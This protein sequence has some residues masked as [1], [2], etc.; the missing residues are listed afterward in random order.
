MSTLRKSTPTKLDTS[1]NAPQLKDLVNTPWKKIV[2][3]GLICSQLLI[4]G[5]LPIAAAIG[6]ILELTA[7]Q[8]G[9][10]GGSLWA[11]GEV[12]FFS[13]IVIL[14]KPVFN[15]LK[16]KVLAFFSRKQAKS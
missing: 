4:F 14:G 7:L 2:F 12:L 6:G 10:L 16:T 15:I 9:S 1:T 8:I 11:L 13:S 3:I 5:F